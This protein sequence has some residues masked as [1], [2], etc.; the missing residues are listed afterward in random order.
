MRAV[1]RGGAA[2][3]R[4]R[5]SRARKR[6]VLARELFACLWPSGCRALNHLQISRSASDLL[7]NSKGQSRIVR[8]IANGAV[9]TTE[10]GTRHWTLRYEAE[11]RESND[12]FSVLVESHTTEQGMRAQLPTHYTLNIFSRHNAG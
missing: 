3:L 12:G 9:Q 6:T 4:P 7:V 11:L 5:I 10:A 8:A 2:V 1:L